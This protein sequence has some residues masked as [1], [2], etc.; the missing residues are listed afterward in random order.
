MYYKMNNNQIIGTMSSGN[1]F[2]KY[3]RE[4]M[5][6][7]AYI[8]ILFKNVNINNN[9]CYKEVK[10][11]QYGWKCNMTTDDC[12]IIFDNYHPINKILYRDANIKLDEFIK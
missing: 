1:V 7:G 12:D 11:E 6:Y 10:Y 8:Q 5:M 2:C 4:R 3:C 9:M